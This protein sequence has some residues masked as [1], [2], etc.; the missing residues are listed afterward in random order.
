MYPLYYILFQLQ[1]IEYIY[2]DHT[3]TDEIT[4][5]VVD[6]WVKTTQTNISWQEQPNQIEQLLASLAITQ[7]QETAILQKLTDLGYEAN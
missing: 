5:E 2:M 1:V 3:N 6:G 4:T 7:D